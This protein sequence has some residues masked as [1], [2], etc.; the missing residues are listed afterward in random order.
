MDLEHAHLRE[1][2]ETGDGIDA[3]LGL[4]EKEERSCKRGGWIVPDRW[5]YAGGP[6]YMTATN[7][8]TLEVYYRY[9]NAFGG[10]KR[11]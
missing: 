8:L 1:R 4:Q 10:A 9:E 6:I 3:V 2:D 7:V 11:N 5:I